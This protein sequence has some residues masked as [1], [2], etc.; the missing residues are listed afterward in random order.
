MSKR[1]IAGWTLLAALL[2]ALGWGLYVWLPPQPRWFVSGSFMTA[3]LSPDGKTFRTLSVIPGREPRRT[4]SPIFPDPPRVT[5]LQLWDVDTGQETRSLLGNAGRVWQTRFSANGQRF[6]AVS[7]QEG[8]VGVTELHVVDLP[9]GR[10]R[11]TSI[12]HRGVHWRIEF[13]P[14]GELLLLED[15]SIERTKNTLF[16][17]DT[18]TL[19]QI[20]KTSTREWWSRKWASG[21]EALLFFEPGKAGD[22]I[23]RRISR[24]GDSVISFKGA[25]DWL[26][27]TPDGKAVITEPPAKDDK[28]PRVV[29]SLM[30]WDLATGK[31]RHTIP[32][33]DFHP[34]A[35]SDN[36]F[37]LRDSRTLLIIH[38]DPRPGDLLGVWDT[39]TAQWL[40]EIRLGKRYPVPLPNHDVFALAT[41]PQESPA[42]LTLYQPRPFKKRWHREWP[43]KMLAAYD[44][45]GAG[46][47]LVTYPS[48]NDPL[49][50]QR[51]ESLDMRTGETCFEVIMAHDA[52]PSWHTLG[53]HLV[54]TEWHDRQNGR[55]ATLRWLEANLLSALFPNL[56]RN[57]QTTTTT[58]VVDKDNGAELCRV[59]LTDTVSGLLS[60][61]GRTLF[62]YQ[63]APPRGV[64]RLFCY[65]VPPRRAWQ[66]IVGIPLAIGLLALAITC[67]WRRWR[68]RKATRSAPCTADG[69]APDPAP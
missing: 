46:E 68:E 54:L 12:A 55:N 59:D 42:G 24:D 20:A 29:D 30:V 57:G 43:D 33:A 25:G 48:T 35:A 58:K 27:L 56:P 22:A 31:L 37:V 18:E 2:F 50:A 51:L 11:H 10:D 60:T 28:W 45:H 65:D 66:Y 62:L 23:L 9:D 7:G 69:P 5:G 41:H 36:L 26:E 17:Y 61:D 39:E 21:D 40:G 67:G 14:G 13:S 52:S 38:G 8:E 19:R 34:R 49:A 6:A 47:N 44:I 16:V 1:R 15:G 4:E 3:G 64:A 53:R 63:E 32:V